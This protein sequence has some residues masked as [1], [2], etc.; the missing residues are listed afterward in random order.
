MQF[1][2]KISVLEMI[3]KLVQM[4]RLQ[5]SC[6]NA[7]QNAMPENF[8]EKKTLFYTHKLLTWTNASK[9]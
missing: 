1:L 2:R 6:V 3:L 9:A 7:L 8:S 5:R 4:I